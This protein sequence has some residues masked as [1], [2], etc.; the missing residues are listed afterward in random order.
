MGAEHIEKVEERDVL[1][2]EEVKEI[3]DNSNVLFNIIYSCSQQI[4]QGSPTQE[5]LVN[6]LNEIG[7]AED[8]DDGVA[9]VKDNVLYMLRND[10]KKTG[11]VYEFATDRLTWYDDGRLMF[12]IEREE[13]GSN[14]MHNSME[15]KSVPA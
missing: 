8:H 15:L 11:I 3:E 4:K 12:Y 14:L 10:V 6:L 2:F 9:E 13:D 1:S 7:N 5:N